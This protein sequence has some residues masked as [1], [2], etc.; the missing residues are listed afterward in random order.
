[1]KL[2]LDLLIK[3]S[4]N[5]TDKKTRILIDNIP[6]LKKLEPSETTMEKWREFSTKVWLESGKIEKLQIKL[7]KDHFYNIVKSAYKYVGKNIEVYD[8]KI[9]SFRIP[10]KEGYF[11]EC[12]NK[13]DLYADIYGMSIITLKIK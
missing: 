10:I 3:K 4:P 2:Y 7:E 11:F 8:E 12:I 1:M 9:N 6:E 5:G 13:L